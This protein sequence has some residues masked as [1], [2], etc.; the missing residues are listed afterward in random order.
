MAVTTDDATGI[1]IAKSCSGESKANSIIMNA[2]PK[3]DD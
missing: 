1:V 3:N 2:I